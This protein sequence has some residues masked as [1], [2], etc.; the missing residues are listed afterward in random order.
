MRQVRL[1]FLFL[2]LSISVFCSVLCSCQRYH[3][4]EGDA[5]VA[6][7]SAYI[8]TEIKNCSFSLWTSSVNESSME[9]CF[10]G[11][12]SLQKVLGVTDCANQYLETHPEFIA[13]SKSM[14]LRISFSQTSQPNGIVKT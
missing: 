11:E 9:L 13:I 2:F 1:L 6:E 14:E 3:Y 10:Q 8:E 4:P 12:C 5:A 7:L